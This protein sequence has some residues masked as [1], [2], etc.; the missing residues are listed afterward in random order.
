VIAD[1]PVVRVDDQ[2][3]RGPWR[4]SCGPRR[5]CVAFIFLASAMIVAVPLIAVSASR[6][7]GWPRRQIAD[8]VDPPSRELVEAPRDPAPAAPEQL[9]PAA[10]RLVDGWARTCERVEQRPVHGIVGDDEH[11]SV[12]DPGQ[13]VK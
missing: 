12:R 9:I 8:D 6:R 4:A 3:K 13:L 10:G 5:H 1:E 2:A 7:V 11:G